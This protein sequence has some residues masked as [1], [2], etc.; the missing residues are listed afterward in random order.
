MLGTAYIATYAQRAGFN[1]GVRDAEAHGLGIK[2]TAQIVNDVAPRWAAM[3]LLAPTY[4]MSARIAKH[5]APEIALMVGGH[6]AR[7]M[8]DRILNDPRMRNL[9]ALVLGAG[10]LRVVALLEDEQRRRELPGGI[11]RD[12]LLGT[13][14]TGI[15]D[16]K[17]SA[18]M[19]GPDIN[20]LPY[21]NRAFLPQ[22]PY[23][24][25]PTATDRSR[26]GPRLAHGRRTG[27]AHR[28]QHR[29]KPRLPLQLHFLWGRVERQ[30]RRQ[31]PRPQPADIIWE[32]DQLHDEYGVT[33]FGSSTICSS[34][35]GTSFTST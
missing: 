11:W 15:A 29:R 7:A 3:N 14:A 13:R 25:A 26:S 34:V 24:A 8:P 12:P 17:T 5:L 27:W 30:P 21:V 32:L 20:T 22:D 2:E 35:C 18:R 16:A 4:E 6:H 1:V 19:L 10:E 28:G 33:C 9:R 31:N 23:Q